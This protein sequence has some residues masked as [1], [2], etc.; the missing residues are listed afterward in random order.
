MPDSSPP[1]EPTAA[2]G[3]AQN[4]AAPPLPTLPPSLEAAPRLPSVHR[5]IR[6]AAAAGFWRIAAGAV[7]LFAVRF[8]PPTDGGAP[9]TKGPW[10]PLGR[11][12]AGD[13]FGGLRDAG[14]GHDA[15]TP[16]TA[17]ELVAVPMPGT[18][19]EDAGLD[20]GPTPFAL[21]DGWVS[22]LLEAA[23]G[24]L[25]PRDLTALDRRSGSG[26]LPAGAAVCADRG[27]LWLVSSESLR[28]YDRD[29]VAPKTPIGLTAAVWVRTSGASP[30]DIVTSADLA[31]HG[32]LS[33]AAATLL[34]SAVERLARQLDEDADGD[35]RSIAA[36]E[37]AARRRVEAAAINL[38]TTLHPTL[39]QPDPAAVEDPLAQACL[40]VMAHEGFAR[41]AAEMR[42]IVRDRRN[43]G[44]GEPVSPAARI[45]RIARGARVRTRRSRLYPGWWRGDFGSFVALRA[46]EPVAVLRRGRAYRLVDGN[47][48]VERVDAAVAATL[49]PDV[50]L[51]YRP[52]P[53]G[54]LNGWSL[55]RFA[56]S[57]DAGSIATILLA[58]AAAA[59]LALLTPAVSAAIFDVIVPNGDYR[60]LETVTI[61]L[62]GAAIGNLGFSVT[63]ALSQLRLQGRVDAVVQAAVWDRLLNLPASFFRGYEVG[64]L[65]SRAAG[66]NTLSSQITGATMSSLFG[67]VFA[68]ASFAMM[69]YYQWQLALVGLGFVLVTLGCSVT[70]AMVQR[71][72]QREQLALRGQLAA[73]IF[74]YIAGIAK[75]RTA[76]AERFAFWD[77]S[78][79]FSRDVAIQRRSGII[80]YS[81]SLFSSGLM[82]GFQAVAF[83]LFAFY[84]SQISIGGFIAF[85][86]AFGQ[87]FSG[88]SSFAG[89]LVTIYGL[90]P[91][92]ERTR[93]ILDATAELDNGKADPGE[94]SGRIALDNVS[95]FYPQANRPVL[96][97]IS[98]NLE[99]GEFVAIV[100]SSGAGKSTL[101]RLLLGFEQPTRGTVSYDGRDLATLDPG[102]VRRQLGVVLQN[103]QILPGSI[104]DN[105][106]ANG[107]YTLDDAWRA[108]AMARLAEDIQAMPMGMQTMISEGAATFSGGQKQRLLI[109]RA[110]IRRPRIL[111]LDEAT[112]ALDNVTQAQ[113]TDA[114][115]RLRTTRLVIAHRLSTIA[116]ADRIVVL[117]G[118]R[119]VQQGSYEALMA[120]PGPFAT[121]ARRQMA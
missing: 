79:R 114:L 17:L 91:L 72:Y 119:I 100:G 21:F 94:L 98:L 105:I 31:A 58:A 117:D 61:V 33:A 7:D 82:L 53:D 56:V 20:E 50:H 83:I 37:V 5:A 110:L 81:Q 120:A 4:A 88:L 59:V 65:A 118:G 67:G 77:W 92:Y 80:V 40:R 16:I 11:I 108:A 10:H 102:A 71:R 25:R 74:Q 93:P 107:P 38:A 32:R 54:P 29:E 36:R 97:G 42:N 95:F 2:N 48:A 113:I 24:P 35:R 12:E 87:F 23:E 69:V 75:L 3:L 15:D 49:E 1:N 112:S 44:A 9:V 64:D 86:A 57:S 34:A 6:L 89:A 109:A 22:R 96:D 51:F 84:L 30:V 73:R 121:L 111:F 115:K 45:E 66:I 104:F 18:R 60:G 46:G 41:D 116:G 43:R 55:L 39:D 28:L 101:L 70:F 14:T 76:G 26:V 19:I 52:F 27:L 13:A 47:G 68:V 63:Q 90:A 62:A 8:A 103:G 106:V 85:N 99:P 78:G